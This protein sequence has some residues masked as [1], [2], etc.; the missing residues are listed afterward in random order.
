LDQRPLCE[1]RWDRGCT[2][3]SVDVHEILPR[4]QGG[5]IVGGKDEE[6][7]CVCRYCHDQIETNPEESHER[8]FR[9][10]SWEK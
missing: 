7:L 10:W 3:I 6:Y 2:S 8:G 1:A 4:S 9:K 5:R